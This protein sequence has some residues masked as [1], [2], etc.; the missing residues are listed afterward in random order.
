[1][2]KIWN[3]IEPW[4]G[5]QQF[6]FTTFFVLVGSWFLYYAIT[7]NKVISPDDLRLVEGTLS[8]YSF[9]D[10][11]KGQYQYYLWLKQYSTSFQ[12]PADFLP[13]FQRRTFDKEIILGQKISLKISKF[14]E[15]KL[16]EL[17]SRIFIYDIQQESKNFLWSELTIKKENS[18]LFYYVGSGFIL[19]GLGFYF[20]R[21]NQLR[22]AHR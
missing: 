18:N 11:E 16:E 9:V 3:Y 19:A 4:I 7:K 2:N 17:Y 5:R 8:N 22:E 13:F 10:K 6:A 14:E 1:M 20:F 15:K 12:I 21:K